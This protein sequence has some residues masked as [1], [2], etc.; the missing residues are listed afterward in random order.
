M[1]KFYDEIPDT[2]RSWIEKQ[3]M[4]WV[5]TA[6]L[7]AEGHVNLSPKGYEDTFFVLGPRR[8]WY[9]DLTGSGTPSFLL[10]LMNAAE[11]V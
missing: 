7:S 3:K 11:I 8:V 4:F 1:G 2:L 5:A 10:P 6:P 9:E